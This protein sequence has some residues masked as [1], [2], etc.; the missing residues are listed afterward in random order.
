MQKRAEKIY[1]RDLTKLMLHNRPY[2]EQA[3]LANRFKRFRNIGFRRR[4]AAARASEQET[5]L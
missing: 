2:A 5:K 1:M 3:R 4:N